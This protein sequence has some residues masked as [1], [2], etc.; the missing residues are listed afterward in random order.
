MKHRHS[1]QLLQ[2][3]VFVGSS[4][5]FFIL[6]IVVPFLLGMYYSFTDWNGVS[7]S[8]NWVGFDNFVHIFTNDP[9]FQTAFWFTVRFT[10][11]GVILTN[12]IG[13]F[14][15]YFLTKPLKTRNILRTIFF[16]PNV[17]GGLLLGFIWQF[18]FVKGFSAVGDV[19]GW[20]VLQ[21]SLA[22][23]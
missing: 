10:V 11:V 9:K 15:A 12:V 23:G 5:V 4:I 6:I 3:L 18:I 22:G 8:I 19:T 21:S 20:L 16:M 17:I 2:Q 7:A 1:S 14:L 13:F